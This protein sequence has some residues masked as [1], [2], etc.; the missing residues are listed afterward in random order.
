[1]RPTTI[2]P[3]RGSGAAL[4]CLALGVAGCSG[5][6]NRPSG[7]TG[8]ASLSLDGSTLGES[9][10]TVGE[11]GPGPQDMSGGGNP[12][13]GEGNELEFS[14]IWIANSAQNSVSKIDTQTMTELGRY[15]VSPSVNAQGPSR[16]AVN[17]SDIWVAAMSGWDP[18]PG[19]SSRIWRIDMTGHG[20]EN[21]G[22][23]PPE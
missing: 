21:V 10:D 23:P 22:F 17:L 15:V 4:R 18:P 1:M 20:L 8:V 9:G 11:S 5:D 2:S 12:C 7:D 3:G 16:T 13:E 19:I 6:A 14:Y